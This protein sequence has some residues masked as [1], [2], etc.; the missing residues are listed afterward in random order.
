M[1]PEPDHLRRILTS[2]ILAPSAEN[3]HDLCFRIGDDSVQLLAT[4]CASWDRRQHRRLLAMMSYGA[5]IENIALR[6][7]A[8]GYRLTETLWPDP[9]RPALIA[10]LRWTAAA[11]VTDPLCDA[12]EAR[13]TNRRFY[14]RAELAPA[15]LA[16]LRDAV[17]AVAGTQLLWLDDAACRSVALRAIRVAETERFRRRELHAELFGA[18]RFECGWHASTDEWLAPASL[19]VESPMRL[20]FAWLRHWSAMRAMNLVGAHVALGLRAGYLPCAL[21]PHIGL[22]VTDGADG[23]LADLRAGR[24]F[25][26][27]WLAAAGENLALQPMA[28]ATALARQAPGHGWVSER[29]KARLQAWLAELCQ[30]RAGRQPHLLFRVGRAEPPS[31]VAGR[32]PLREYVR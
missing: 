17:D 4:D 3:K 24:A 21:A 20:P 8:L 9:A 10:E 2:G 11:P 31:V 19:Q 5:V 18:V 26:R 23:P 22:I 6:S 13:H 12:I 32:R 7:A 28:A 25:Q 1:R 15:T 27:V 14:R 29:V 30:H 16:H